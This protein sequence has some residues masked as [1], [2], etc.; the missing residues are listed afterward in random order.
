MSRVELLP[1]LLA[2]PKMRICNRS[3]AAPSEET[4]V[5]VKVFT[6]V[7]LWLEEVANAA[8]PTTPQLEVTRTTWAL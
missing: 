1:P 4:L 3:V 7:P 2:V 8:P 6:P 5:I